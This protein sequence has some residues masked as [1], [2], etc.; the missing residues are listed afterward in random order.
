MTE[1]IRK[2]NNPLTIIAIF[3]ALAEINATISLG[4]I[5]PELQDVFIWFIIGFPSL[6]VLL[7]FLTWNFNPKVM[8]APS[9]FKDEKIF[10]D[11]LKGFGKEYNS[12]QINRDNIDDVQKEL[13]TKELKEFK[14]K[15]DSANQVQYLNYA[16]R[17]FSSFLELTKVRFEKG[18]F[19]EMSFGIH[20]ENYFLLRLRLNDKNL[21]RRAT[22]ENSLILFL[23]LVDKK[24]H[25]ELI[26]KGLGSNDPEDLAKKTFD[27]FDKMIEK[28]KVEYKIQQEADV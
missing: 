22:K 6:L 21:P 15:T 19:A 20:E 9:D 26:G 4:L 12:I 3:A 7:F 24:V 28:Y 14:L 16:N 13:K 8:Y 23:N 2:I 27:Y 11:T 10:L 1:N 17:F 25:G 18:T 5:K